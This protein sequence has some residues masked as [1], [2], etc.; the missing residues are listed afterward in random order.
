MRRHPEPSAPPV[1]RPARAAKLGLVRWTW[2]LCRLRQ[3]RRLGA[4][5]GCGSRTSVG[6]FMRFVARFRSAL[7]RLPLQGQP[8]APRRW[9]KNVRIHVRPEHLHRCRCATPPRK[10]T[11]RFGFAKCN[12][13]L[14]IWQ[15]VNRRDNKMDRGGGLSFRS[16]TVLLI[17]AQFA[18]TSAKQAPG[19]G[20]S[21]RC[22]LAGR[23]AD[24]RKRIPTRAATSPSST[25]V[26]SEVRHRSPRRQERARRLGVII[27]GSL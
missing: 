1:E 6:F 24:V 22:P 27:R 5:V 23:S 3:Q 8:P 7:T 20:I 18:C 9:W 16:I 11:D 15:E 26:L 14:L 25:T 13:P 10:V 17:K 4:C 12:R 19:G 2:R 21:S